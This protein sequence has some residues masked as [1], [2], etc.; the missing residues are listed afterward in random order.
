MRAAALFST[1]LLVALGIGGASYLLLSRQPNE[2]VAPILII[3][4][5]CAVSMSLTFWERGLY[6]SAVLSGR[7]LRCRKLTAAWLQSVGLA[8]LFIFVLINIAD[9]APVVR[10]AGQTLH[11]IWLPVFVMAGLAALMAIRCVRRRSPW[12]GTPA[13]R[14]AVV[15]TTEICADFLSRFRH[16][17]DPTVE[18]VGVIEHEGVLD[19][20]EME[21]HGHPIIGGIDTLLG[22]IRRDQVDL[23]LV[24]LPWCNPEHTRAT[25]TRIATAPVD[26]FM[27]PGLDGFAFCDRPAMTCAGVPLLLAS[28]RPLDGWQAVVKRGEDL[29]LA[30]LLLLLTAPAMIAI[31]IAVKLTSRGPIFFRQPRMGFNNQVIEVLKFRTM[32]EHLSD[33]G[34][35]QQTA[36]NDKRVTRV[37]AFLR[38]ASLDELPQLLNVVRGDMSLVGPRPHALE[39]TAGGLPLDVAAPEYASR[40]RVKPGITG[41]AQVNGHRGALDS[42]EKIVNRVNHDLYYIENWSLCLDLKILLK[43]AVLMVID[44]NAF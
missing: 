15:G 29:V 20:R 19:S 1:D 21:F 6:A 31:S 9:G 4:G 37:G 35:A 32:Y 17:P 38:R 39:T 36:R 10:H 5:C 11:G 14:A 18:I 23:V 7:E 33:K 27:V 13:R 12:V 25:V 40:H 44:E 24:A 16:R 30:S 34:A 26:V 22:L 3:L 2:S 42:V 43:T 41:W 28:R 8:L